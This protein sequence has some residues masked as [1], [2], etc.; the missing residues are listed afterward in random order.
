MSLHRR[1]RQLEKETRP[2][3]GI[4]HVHIPFVW[5]ALPGRMEW[6]VKIPLPPLTSVP[7]KPESP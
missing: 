6:P 2:R 3:L 7:L 4:A 5:M 1:I